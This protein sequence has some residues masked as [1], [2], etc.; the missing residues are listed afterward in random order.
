[1]FWRR[2][3]AALSVQPAIETVSRT[4]LDAALEGAADILRARA[5]FVLPV[6][7]ANPESIATTFERWAT[8]LLV[9]SPPPRDDEETLAREVEPAASD[10][11]WRGLA[12]FVAI[13]AR[14]EQEFVQS[15]VRD[16]RDAIFAL[17]ESF[18]RTSYARGRQE[19]ALR[20]RL[21]GLTLAVESGSVEELKRE[22][23]AIAAAV[24]E[25]IEE[26]QSLAQR[27]ADE[28]RAR[29]VSL[30]EQLEQTRREGE[31][32][33]LTRLANRRVFDGSIGRALAV[34]FVID[35]PL[36]LMMVDV[37]HFKSVNDAHGHPVGDEVLRVVA[38]TLVRTFPRRSDLVAR[39]GGEEFAILFSDSGPEELAVLGERLL[40]AVRK[41]R[42]EVG[43]KSIAVTVSAG[44]A[45]AQP[46]EGAR[47]LVLR[48]DMALYAAKRAGRNRWVVAP[49]TDA[50]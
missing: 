44:L 22:A 46:N 23:I 5:R 15:S 3:A 6:R 21:A 35:R 28:L 48:A 30:N 7:D 18:S 29:L 12:R 36:T 47:E 25:V 8:H 26:Q 4:E 42:I 38:D 31:T 20:R 34:S 39:Y 27:Q 50:D 11:D 41:L 33:P 40:D 17:V 24:T 45:V 13:H 16:M 9:R 32:D 14:K 37:D 49:A 1:M 19:V 2:K 10:R 43:G